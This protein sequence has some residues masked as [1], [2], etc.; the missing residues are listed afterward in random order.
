MA[1]QFSDHSASFHVVC[2]TWAG[3]GWCR[4]ICRRESGWPHLW[5]SLVPK[6]KLPSSEA[7]GKT[8]TKLIRALLKPTLKVNAAHHSACT[9]E[10]TPCRWW[11]FTFPSSFHR[12]L[13]FVLDVGNFVDS[14]TKEGELNEHF[15]LRVGQP[16]HKHLWAIRPFG[17]HTR[18]F[19]PTNDAGPI[20]P[21]QSSHSI[22]LFLSFKQR[23]Q[24]DRSPFTM[25]YTLVWGTKHM[26]QT[27]DVL[28]SFSFSFFF[29][30]WQRPR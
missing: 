13:A 21:P 15:I 17:K 14:A 5:F 8:P 11:A 27:V 28:G 24:K 19:A 3:C 9:I 16:P 2:F 23:P 26:L 18:P 22:F 29:F 7:L 4:W 10:S 6:K 20:A 12:Y 25:F 1:N 30:F